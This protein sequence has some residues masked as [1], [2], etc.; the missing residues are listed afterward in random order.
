MTQTVLEILST[1]NS[2]ME[3]DVVYQ[4]YFLI[5]TSFLESALRGQAIRVALEN[6]VN[7][8]EVLTD[9][10]TPD[11]QKAFV[12]FEKVYKYYKL[13][14]LQENSPTSQAEILE[15]LLLIYETMMRIKNDAECGRP[16]KETTKIFFQYF[17]RFLTE[18]PQ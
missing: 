3:L 15:K 9:I 4:E 11:E 2:F 17:L 10:T 5:V 14:F 8:V 6:K 13:T 12:D 16:K 7:K 18:N 1:P